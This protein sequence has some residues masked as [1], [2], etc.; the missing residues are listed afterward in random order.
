MAKT[1]IRVALR[2]RRK[3]RI[4]GKISGTAERPRLSVFRST[5]HVYAQVIDDAEGKTLVQVSSFEK[6]NHRRA[7]KE[8]CGELGKLLAER[9]QAKNIGSVVFDK[10]GYKYH[11]RIQILADAAREG[12][13]VF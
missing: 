8:V 11:G 7:N 9:C 2:N 5:S 12:G 6:G 13:L 10:N 1:S 4:R 3:K